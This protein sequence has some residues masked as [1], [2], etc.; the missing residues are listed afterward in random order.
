MWISLLVVL[1]YLV[2]CS[3]AVLTLSFIPPWNSDLGKE[4]EIGTYVYPAVAGGLVFVTVIYYALFFGFPKHSIVRLAS[5]EVAVKSMCH[6]WRHPW[7]GYKYRVF[8]TPIGDPD[9]SSM[10]RM[11]RWCFG[12][13]LDSPSARVDPG[14]ANQVWLEN[15]GPGVPGCTCFGPA[16]E[17]QPPP[18]QSPVPTQPEAAHV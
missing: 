12:F 15:H 8:I 11:L 3:I 4:K 7:F 10:A 18:P 6:R 16:L 13:T 1:P 17:M 5:V 14:R 9:I 2:G